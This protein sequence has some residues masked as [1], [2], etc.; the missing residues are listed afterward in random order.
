MTLPAQ[1][2]RALTPPQRKLL[3]YIVRCGA[4][5][6]KGGQWRTVDVLERL[7]LVDYEY[8]SHS[9]N[10]SSAKWGRIV[11]TQAGRIKV[12]PQAGPDGR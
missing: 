1:S 7:G 5:S 11:P 9:T 2:T 3:R 8:H 10:G 4:I 12:R 6:P